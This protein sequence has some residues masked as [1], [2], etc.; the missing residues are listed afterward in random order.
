MLKKMVLYFSN[1]HKMVYIN[2]MRFFLCFIGVF[3]SVGLYS[4]GLIAAESYKKDKLY[5]IEEADDN[6]VSIRV[7]KVGDAA[8]DDMYGVQP[9]IDVTRSWHKYLGNR[10]LTNGGSVDIKVYCHGVTDLSV[11]TPYFLSNKEYLVSPTKIINGRYIS[12]ADD[13]EKNRVVVIDEIT[14]LLLFESFD[15]IGKKISF[16][17]GPW[18]VISFAVK[19]RKEYS[20]VFFFSSA[21][22]NSTYCFFCS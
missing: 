16:K 2:K 20:I 10:K 6:S 7:E 14:S 8:L 3:I 22:S 4:V 9:I 1:I 15:S 18:G 17:D 19:D 12:E 21:D 13:F 11:V 5:A